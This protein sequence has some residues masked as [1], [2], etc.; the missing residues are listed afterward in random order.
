MR[1]GMETALQEG[2]R[3]VG[4]GAEESDQDGGYEDRLRILGLTTLETR[5]LRADL[6]EVFKILRG[7]ENL[8]LDRYFQVIGDGARKGHSFKLF[9]KRY[10]LDEGKFKF[11]SRVCEEWN[12]LG[13]EIVSAGTVNV[14]KTRLDHHLNVRGYL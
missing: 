7:F 12:R 9:K 13:D 10:R 11:A 6:I 3:Q 5:F 2:Y 14:F 4:E 1:A 8:D